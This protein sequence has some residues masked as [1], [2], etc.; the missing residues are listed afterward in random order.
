MSFALHP[1]LKADTLPIIDLALCRVLL[2]R[3]ATYPWLI[4]VPRVPEMRELIDLSPADCTTVMRE[5]RTASHVLCAVYQPDK[6][7]VAALGNQVPQLHIHVIA[8]YHSD[9]AW[10]RPVWGATPP[11]PYSPTQLDE[12]QVL[13]AEQFTQ[14]D[15][16]A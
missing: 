11:T 14:I 7:N 15:L 6:L 4:L 3:D 1:V 16:H 5:I 9:P 2:M 13:L 12:L 8:R 10:P